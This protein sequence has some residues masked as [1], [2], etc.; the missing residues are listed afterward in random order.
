MRGVYVV[1]DILMPEKE[2]I[3]TIMEL[4]RR[5]P[6]VKIVAISG[7]GQNDAKIFLNL[8][9]NL[10]ANHV[11]SKPFRNEQL[12]SALESCLAQH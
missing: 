2:G 8:A 3:E 7:G 10:G 12:L 9:N 5:R 1:T 11:L 6:R 4:R